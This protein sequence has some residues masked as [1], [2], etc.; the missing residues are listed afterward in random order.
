MAGI[1]WALLRRRRPQQPIYDHRAEVSAVDP[2][3][4]AAAAPKP[5]LQVSST[6][7]YGKGF[8]HAT[9]PPQY[10][11][12]PEHYDQHQNEQYN[13]T[14]GRMMSNPASEMGDTGYTTVAELRG[15]GTR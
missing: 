5:A 11:N 6:P 2:L 3:P 4:A 14:Q 7:V 1:F 15:D 10:S 13:A 12:A 9:Q 8:G